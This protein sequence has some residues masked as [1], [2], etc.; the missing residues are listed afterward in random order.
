M[1]RTAPPHPEAWTIAAV[2]F[3]TIGVVLAYLI[4]RGVMPKVSAVA[5]S[6]FKSEVN[7]PLF[8]IV[9][10]MG[11]VALAAFVFI[12]YNTFG[13]DIKVLK[14]SGMTLIMVLCIIQAVWA[15]STSVA[16]EIEGRTALTVLSKPIG[17]RSFIIGKYLGIFWT[18]AVLF[19]LLGLCLLICVAY[20]PIY[21]VAREPTSIRAGSF[22]TWR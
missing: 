6:T 12:P 5:L 9:L 8:M 15:A 1:I 11:L 16:D 22:A 17:R 18:V 21:D 10:I 3:A 19:V 4:Q 2:A 13:E 14:D 7:Q 20:K